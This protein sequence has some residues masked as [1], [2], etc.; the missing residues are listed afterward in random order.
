MGVSILV[1][2]LAESKDVRFLRASIPGGWKRIESKD[3][4]DHIVF[5]WPLRV[6]TPIGACTQVCYTHGYVG[7][8]THVHAHIFSLSP[9]LYRI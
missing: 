7:A 2:L 6:S 1:C 5:P 8:C 4:P 3:T 9:P